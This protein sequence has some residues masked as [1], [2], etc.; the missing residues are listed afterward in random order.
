[1]S[2]GHPGADIMEADADA[3]ADADAADAA[4]AGEGLPKRFAGVCANAFE[5]DSAVEGTES[6]LKRDDAASAAAAC[7]AAADCSTN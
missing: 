1:M 6:A 7:A 3:D 5:E 4:D 2:H